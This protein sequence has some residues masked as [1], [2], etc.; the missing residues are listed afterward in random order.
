M[1]LARDCCL[2]LTSQGQFALSSC[3]KNSVLAMW[4]PFTTSKGGT[5]GIANLQLDD[6]K[7]ET[8]LKSFIQDKNVK[9]VS[10]LV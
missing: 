5:S 3:Q 9:L 8:C 2:P 6:V 7:T 4:W 1:S 10:I